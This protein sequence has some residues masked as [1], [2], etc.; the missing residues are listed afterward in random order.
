MQI[1]FSPFN[2]SFQY[3]KQIVLYCI[4]FEILM[5]RK[6]KGRGKGG[7]RGRG[8]GNDQQETRP[9]G[10][11][12]SAES[13]DPPFSEQL[14]SLSQA[15]AQPVSSQ[16][17]QKKEQSVETVKQTS[18]EG[19]FVTSASTTV[20][21]PSQPSSSIS[22]AAAQNLRDVG[23]KRVGERQLDGGQEQKQLS[24]KSREEAVKS[25]PK[26]DTTQGA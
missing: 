18:G 22:G 5:P 23:Q 25:T 1:L 16:I 15:R 10:A 6:P 21:S 2:I 17:S 4:V 8:R 11:R 19:D 12:K 14:P 26:R 9:G 20:K 24:N 13:N 3:L 7:G